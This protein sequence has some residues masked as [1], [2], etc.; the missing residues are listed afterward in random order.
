M[1]EK[2]DFSLPEKKSRGGAGGA[3]TVLLLLVVAALA[4]AN[5]VVASRGEKG[6][7][8]AASRGLSAAQVK[9]LAAKLAQRNLHQQASAVWQDYLAGAELTDTERAKVLFQIAMSFEKAGQYAN[10]IE[11]YYRSESTAPLDELGSQINTHVKECFE[12]LGKFSSLR[13][14]MMDRTSLTSSEPAGGRVVAEIGNEKIT[15]ADLDAAAERVIEGQ[16][17]SAEAFMT[18]EQLNEQKKRALEQYSSGPARQEFLQ[19]WLA[20]EILYRQALEDGLGDKPRTKRVLEDLARGV[21]SQEL[22]NQKLASGVSI[23]ETDVQTYYAAHKDQYVEPA[24]AQISH[25]RVSDEGQAHELLKRIKGGED[26]AALAQE[27]SEDQGSK[28]NGGRIADDVGPGPSV[29]GI[30]DA[31]EINAAIFAA[32]GAT[33]LDKPFQT[34]QG[35][36]IVRVEEKSSER[37]RSFDEAAQQVTTDLLRRKRQEVQNKYI[38]EMMDKY[39]VVIHTSVFAPAQPSDANEPSSQK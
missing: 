25:L 32:E 1:A 29:P 12:R 37:Q 9:E 8:T 30:G 4:A 31:N 23:T 15:E 39:N 18:T 10:A 7:P 19:N 11:N 3:F 20:Q 33:V 5:L 14:E 36:E 38:K 35:W 24:R 6:Q 21:L 27:F 13:Y 34:D 16:L 17:S 26:F 22:M 28:D 2:L